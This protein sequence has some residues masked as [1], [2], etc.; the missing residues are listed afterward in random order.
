[1]TKVTK[2]LKVKF[3]RWWRELHSDT[4]FPSTTTHLTGA[5]IF[6]RALRER[7]A[8]FIL[9]PVLNKRIIKVEK[10]GLYI[11][12]QHSILT[13][14][15]HKYSYILEINYDMYTKLAKMFDQKV[16]SSYMVEENTIN[17]QLH[18]GLKKVLELFNK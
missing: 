9:M 12:L 17:E 4:S 15:N 10:K 6:R 18:G 3:I 13:I 2:R 5:S 16:E 11:V 7:S 1:M 8:E 14:T